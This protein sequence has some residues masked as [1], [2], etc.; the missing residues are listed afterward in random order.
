MFSWF[1][2]SPW[3]LL[4]SELIFSNFKVNLGKCLSIL[5]IFSQRIKS[6]FQWLFGFVI[7]SS[8]TFFLDI[9]YSCLACLEV[10]LP[11]PK[12]GCIPTSNYDFYVCMYM[13]PFVLFSFVLLILFSVCM[14]ALIFSFSVCGDFCIIFYWERERAWSWVGRIWKEWGSAAHMDNYVPYNMS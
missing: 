7:V 14:S 2:E 9:I 11:H 10:Y 6:S 12:A 4:P 5:L 1:S 3:C 8:Q 13:C